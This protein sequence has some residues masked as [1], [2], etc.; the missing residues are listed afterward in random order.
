MEAFLARIYQRLGHRYVPALVVLLI[1]GG[2]GMAAASSAAAAR[3]LDAGVGQAVR[4]FAVAGIQMVLS[5]AIGL[6]AAR[7]ELRALTAWIKAGEPAGDAT[8]AWVA[9]LSL[10][11]RVMSWTAVLIVL[12]GWPTA[13][14]AAHE[15]DVAT[16]TW[17][18]LYVGAMI[19]LAAG[20]TWTV[21]AGEVALRPIVLAAVR[22]GIGDLPA[23]R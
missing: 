18:A 19:V 3:Y 12:G 23:A 8:G 4:V 5:I 13:I 15:F 7:G 6:V 20:A 16:S 21:F 11:G 1:L 9:A 17:P 2:V 10:P 22:T 14:Y